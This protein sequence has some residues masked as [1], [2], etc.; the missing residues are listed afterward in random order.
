MISDKDKEKIR[1]E[2]RCILDKFGSSLKNVKLSK[3]GFKNE[4]G[5]FRNEEET[6]SGDEYFRKRMFANAPSIEGDCVLAEKKKW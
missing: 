3:E 2:S 4:V 6:L 1:N 5:G